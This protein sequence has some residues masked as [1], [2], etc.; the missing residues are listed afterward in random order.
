MIFITHKHLVRAQKMTRS[1]LI[2]AIREYTDRAEIANF[3][4][5]TEDFKL[6]ARIRDIYTYELTRRFYEDRGIEPPKV[7]VWNA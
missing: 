3:Y 6:F 2:D 7:K 1:K 5:H 4:R